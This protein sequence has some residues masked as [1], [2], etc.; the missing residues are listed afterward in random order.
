MKFKWKR[1]KSYSLVPAQNL[2]FILFT[3]PK[4]GWITELKSHRN[5]GWKKGNAN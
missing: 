4:K 5:D 1:I 2:T 3:E